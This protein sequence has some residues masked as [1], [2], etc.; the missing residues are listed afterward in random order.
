MEL[1]RSR[2][3]VSSNSLR[4]MYCFRSVP[5]SWW[6]VAGCRQM[7]GCSGRSEWTLAG[8]S[9]VDVGRK[10]RMAERNGRSPLLPLADA[11]VALLVFKRMGL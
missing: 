1:E 2:E 10:R 11:E 5:S 7:K 3:D 9:N 8:G 6:G 4:K